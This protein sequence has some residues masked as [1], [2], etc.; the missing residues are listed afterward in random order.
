L[1]V[2]LAVAVTGVASFYWYLEAQTI[3]ARCGSDPPAETS[4]YRHE[5]EWWPFAYVCVYDD[6]GGEV[7]RR[8]E[9]PRL[10][11]L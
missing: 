3:G 1:L 7:R 2:A 10:G 9:R 11:D 4:G 5:W 6:R 8:P